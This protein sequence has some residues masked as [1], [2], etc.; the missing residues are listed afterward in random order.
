MQHG[1]SPVSSRACKRKKTSYR[2]RDEE[3]SDEGESRSPMANI[4]NTRFTSLSP[5]VGGAGEGAQASAHV[6]LITI[7]EQVRDWR[8][9]SGG[10]VY[11]TSKRGSLLDYVFPP[12]HL[13]NPGCPG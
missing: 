11:F 12:F 7:S 9:V 10:R 3:D 1:E 4:G 8:P 13:P 2:D 5:M 6:S